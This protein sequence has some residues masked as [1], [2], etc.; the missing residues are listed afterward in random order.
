MMCDFM[1]CALTAF[2][3]DPEY[4][5]MWGALNLAIC[6]W[7]YRRMVISQYSAKT[8]KLSIQGPGP[9]GRDF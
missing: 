8:P 1:A 4:A 2:S 3:R 5:R 9:D 6:A 7:L